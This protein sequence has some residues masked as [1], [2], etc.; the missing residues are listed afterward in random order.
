[1][2]TVVR[3]GD[4][5]VITLP[6]GV[7]ERIYW[8]DGT[9]LYVPPRPITESQIKRALTA[10]ER[11]G[12]RQAVANDEEVADWMDYIQSAMRSGD[13]LSVEDPVL[14]A[15]FLRLRTLGVFTV[16]RLQELQALLLD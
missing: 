15:G 3:E 1:M 14:R 16:A 13:P 12:I 4:Y 5:L 8:P 9:V 11:A 7:V 6:S 10:A 2:S